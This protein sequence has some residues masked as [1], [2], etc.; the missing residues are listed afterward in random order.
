MCSLI[1]F[2]LSF[3]TSEK[4]EPVFL[5]T[6]PCHQDQLMTDQPKVATSLVGPPPINSLPPP[7]GVG[8]KPHADVI[9]QWASASKYNMVHEPVDKHNVRNYDD[10]DDDDKEED[11]SDK[12]SDQTITDSDEE[13]SET[14]EDVISVLAQ[15]EVHEAVDS[16]VRHIIDA[17]QGSISDNFTVSVS[18]QLASTDASSSF[19][20]QCYH[21]NKE[22][23]NS[24]DE[25]SWGFEENSPPPTLPHLTS[26]HSSNYTHSST[27]RDDEDES[28][29]LQEVT[30]YASPIYPSDL[31]SVTNDL[32]PSDIYPID[33]SSYPRVLRS[34]DLCPSPSDLY[35]IDIF[36]SDLCTSPSNLCP[37]LSDP[38]PINIFPSDLCPSPSDLFPSHF[39][40]S[41]Q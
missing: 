11:V 2:L 23:D 4:V 12:P 33:L 25:G 19:E 17:S 35:P 30:I 41:Y 1:F 27:Y 38:Y 13:A 26:R 10:D 37:S 7:S 34:C 22:S 31:C 5:L 6:E 36:L 40:T 8:M 24:Q 16:A 15:R 3:Q 21:D 39:C 18:N 9:E 20:P 28:E 29:P 14:S 32:C